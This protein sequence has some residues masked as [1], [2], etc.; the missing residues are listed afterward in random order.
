MLEIIFYLCVGIGVGLLSGLFGIGGGIIIIPALILILQQ[1]PQ[2]EA[3]NI[4]H[5]A[6]CSSLIIISITAISS[7]RA[8]HKR[9]A[10]IW[11]LFWKIIPGQC[12]GLACGTVLSYGLS[13]QILTRL[14]ALFLIL[15]AGYL[16]FNAKY[17]YSTQHINSHNHIIKK[18][19]Q[20]ILLGGGLIVGLLSA[21]FGIGGGILLV[22][23]FIFMRRTIQ[24][25][26]GTSALC[27]LVSGL[28]GTFFLAFLPHPLAKLPYM[29]GN[30][31]LPGVLFIGVPSFIFAPLGTRLAFYW[32][33]TLLK[34]LFAGLLIISA[35]NLI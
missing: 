17:P 35:L 1:Q 4:M 24:E 26:S 3:A 6:A 14:F 2:F 20:N 12:I 23:L 28:V 31:Y 19:D 7:A 29:L 13:N 21:L 8:Y 9:Q 16:W 5:I 10:L 25:A 11:P 18:K 30:I 27:G 34:Q 22:P 32:K 15:V 33:P